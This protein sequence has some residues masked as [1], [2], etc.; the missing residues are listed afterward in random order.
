MRE[1]TVS[2]IVEKHEPLV[3]ICIPTYNGALFIADAIDSV[4]NQTYTNWELIVS[5]DGS[6]DKTTDIVKSYKSG[7]L[8]TAENMG[9]QVIL[10]TVY[11]KRRENI[12]SCFV[13]MT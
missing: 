12:L 9:W 4:L 6:T 10:K 5:D 1:N 7:L 8:K 2:D 13:R 11:I 3:S